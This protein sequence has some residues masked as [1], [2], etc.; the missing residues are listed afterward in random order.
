MSNIPTRESGLMDALRLSG[1][2]Y[3]SLADGEGVRTALY[4]SGCDHNCPG[5][6]NREAQDFYTGQ[7]V[8]SEI[9][10]QIV[11]EINKRPYLSGITLTGG[12]P[13]YRPSQLAVALQYIKERIN[14]HLSVWLYT[15]FRW[16]DVEGLYLMEYVDV[17]VD[18]PYIWTCAD[19]RLQYRG[20]SN[21]RVIDV[22][23][24]RSAGEVVLYV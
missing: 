10:Q 11:D 6:H 17:I 1:V 8:T 12:D 2:V 15:G 20:S 19:K 21:Q 9:L 23:R 13:L 22:K 7:I 3:D 5:C 14:P 16:E 4:F 18:G 24:T